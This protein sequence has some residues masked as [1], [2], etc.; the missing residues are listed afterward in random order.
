MRCNK[1][2]QITPDKSGTVWCVCSC[3]P[4]VCVYGADTTE[5]PLLAGSAKVIKNLMAVSRTRKWL[6]HKIQQNRL[7]AFTYDYIWPK[8][9][10]VYICTLHRNTV[11]RAWRISPVCALSAPLP[12]RARRHYARLS[13]L[14]DFRAHQR[15]P[16]KSPP[17]E[18]IKWINSQW[19]M[20]ASI[21]RIGLHI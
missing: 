1:I 18:I 13:S 20:I 12:L 4:S 17:Q 9:N 7:H 15:R 16:R 19:T 21:F 10:A 8:I 6:E 14:L 11:S 3:A 2:E 5:L